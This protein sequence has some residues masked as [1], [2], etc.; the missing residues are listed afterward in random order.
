M[1]EPLYIVNLEDDP[2]DTELIQTTLRSEGIECHIHRV[3][4]KE[5]FLT[6]I[7]EDGVTLILADYSLPA[8]DGLSALT[9]ACERCPE[10]P[11]IFVTGAMGEEVAV[12]SL[13]QG[14]TDYVLKDNLARL[15]PVVKR[16]LQEAENRRKRQLAEERMKASLHEK[17]I[18][19]RELY[20][21]T[22]NNMQVISSM[23]TLQASHHPDMP[24]TEF[25][26][27]IEHKLEA[28]ALVHEKL[29]Q[30]KDLSRIRLD[31]YLDDLTQ[32]LMQSHGIASSGISFERDMEQ[33]AVLID[34]AIPCG[35][36]LNELVSN[37]IKHAFPEGQ[38]GTIRLSLLRDEGG[39]IELWYSDNGVGV[40]AD[41]DFCSQQTLGF[42]TL[43]IIAEHQLK[44]HMTFN[45]E[46]GLSCSLRFKD[47]LYKPRV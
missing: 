18:L 36:I 12:E 46:H 28:M 43:F 33:I 27:D 13:K 16:A 34:T 38:T 47:N 4:G 22:K 1:Q 45:G 37:T 29:Y 10:T 25:V 6:A 3:E 14:A 26:A 2:I 17:D 31:E 23:L 20:H 30:A 42:K 11:F 32:L 7:E 9:L 21:R 15:A 40:P 8:F 24:L 44:G 41:F 19:L 35:L 5:D 39:E